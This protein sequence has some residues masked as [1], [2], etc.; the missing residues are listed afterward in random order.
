MARRKT[1]S[2]SSKPRQPWRVP[3]FRVALRTLATPFA[4]L[5][6]KVNAQSLHRMTLGMAWTAAAIAVAAAW[7]LGVPRLQ[8]FA[9]NERFAGI[10]NV[11]FVDAPRWFNG[12]L[13][14]HLLQTAEMHL[15]GDPMRR[16]DLVACREALLATGWFESVA[17]VRRVA[18]DQVEI[19]AVFVRPY[20][21][22]RDAE[23]DHLVDVVGRLLPLKYD[24]GARTSFIT[25]TG[26]HFHRPQQCGE[27]WEGA[28]VIA[29]LR[30]LNVIDQQPWRNQVTH[31]D[32][33]NHLSGE[34]IRLKTDKDTSIIWGNAPGEEAALEVLAEG[35]LRRLNYMFEKYHRVDAGETGGELD[36][37]N[38]K[39]VLTR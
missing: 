23:G 3:R 11:R 2:R 30:L 8:A 21:V 13:S 26:A 39:A 28:D 4:V 1:K 20:A 15:A 24:L 12:D 6:A 33:T 7:M 37:T 27:V 35:K 29:A 17:Q 22:L 31:V 34:P 5:A 14:Q 36:I 19:E 25:I 10:V 38:E 16:D 18:P 32:V 9:S